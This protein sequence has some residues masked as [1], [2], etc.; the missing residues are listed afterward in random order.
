[1]TRR[2]IV[3]LA[4][5]TLT[6]PLT[7]DGDRRAAD[8]AALAKLQ[9]FV[10]EWK[11]VGRKKR[12]S[13]KGAWK[14]TAA[15]AWA[16]EGGRAGL[17]LV[18][19]D[20]RFVTDGMLLPVAERAGKFTFKATLKGDKT[21]AYKGELGK[22]G[23]LVLTAAKASSGQPARITMKTV[24]DGDR[25][26]VLFERKLGGSTFLRLGEIGYTRSG[27]GFG[28]GAKGSE[29]I[30]TGGKGTIAVSYKGKTYYVC[31]SGCKDLFDEDPAAIIKEWE[32]AQKKKGE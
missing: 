25:L 15:W 17:K 12:N 26:V 30:V 3:L 20:G 4:L 23:E 16:F 11:G 1:M 2:W 24:A 6:T 13:G 27:S 32:A 14:E 10:G 21:L 22:K 8:Q 5:L 28:K 7:A 29:C 31:C 18:A 19:P 9:D